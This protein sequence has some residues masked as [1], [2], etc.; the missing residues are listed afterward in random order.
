MYPVLLCDEAPEEEKGQDEDDRTE[1]PEKENAQDDDDSTANS[2]SSSDDDYEAVTNANAIVNENRKGIRRMLRLS[3]S[4]R[5][6]APEIAIMKKKPK[7]W[8]VLPWKT[9]KGHPDCLTD[10]L[11]ETASDLIAKGKNRS[12]MTRATNGRKNHPFHFRQY[13]YKTGT[14]LKTSGNMRIITF[15]V[16]DSVVLHI[17]TQLHSSF[18]FPLWRPGG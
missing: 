13:V 1:D 10:R 11:R 16:N 4:P 9:L 15:F 6:K 8:D 18:N 7:Y 17:Y 14:S 2:C 3:I 5:K 12:N